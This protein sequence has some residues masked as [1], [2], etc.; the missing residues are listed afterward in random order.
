MAAHCALRTCVPTVINMNAVFVLLSKS[1][2]E[3]LILRKQSKLR[4]DIGLFAA[5][6]RTTWSST[7]S[8]TGCT[9]GW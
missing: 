6:T 7:S 3:G 4:L 2:V 8:V 9:R 5:G 1:R